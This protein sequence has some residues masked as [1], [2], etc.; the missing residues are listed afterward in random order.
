MK[1]LLVN[2]CLPYPY[3]K[4]E[5]TY[6]RIWPPLC[7]ANC[8]ALLEKEGH[9]VK[10]FDAHARRTAAEKIVNYIGGYDKIFITSSPLDRWQCPNINI[11]PF[12]E[13]VRRIGDAHEEV[14][15]MGYHGTAESEKILRLTKA[16]AV[17]RGEPE[18][19]VL[20]ICRNAELTQIKGVTFFN[21]ENISFNLAREPLGMKTLPVPAF[22]L[23]DF[24]K[25]S[26]EILGDR[27]S[28]FEISRGCY[29]KCI[30]CN[31]I[32]YGDRVRS[33]SKEQVLEEI[34][35][36]VES[37][38]VRTG[39][40]MDLD[41]LSCKEIVEQICDYLIKKEYRFRWAC[42]TRADLLDIGILNKMK[43]A[44]CRIIHL[45]I[46]AVRQEPLD[47]L[48]KNITVEEIE[49]A[50][51]L[52]KKSGI[53]TLAFFLFGLPNETDE[54][55]RN[56]LRHIKALNFDFVSFHGITPYKGAG[57]C[58]DRVESS[59]VVDKFIHH[60]FIEYYLRPSRLLCLDLSLT[61]KSIKLLYGRIKSL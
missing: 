57:L 49:R 48:N 37:Y 28:L 45:G 5:Y 23:L 56:A 27:F 41:F 7:L 38:G 50:V 29:S 61:S 22:H 13:T 46:E 26:Y 8:A 32:M 34:T 58:C 15:I 47:Y 59:A 40:F 54:D 33:K 30:F 4:G 39:Y 55:R 60:A 44:G 12:L 43:A 20:E 6:N 1:I 25:Y 35:L 9:K 51:K 24:R 10:I 31:K 2:P 18:E 16:K 11:S 21:G 36:A 3:S 14:Y 17:I 42:Q 19:T 53:M 52:C